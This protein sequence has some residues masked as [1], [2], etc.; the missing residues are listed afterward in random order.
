MTE[1][2]EHEIKECIAHINAMIAYCNKNDIE[3]TLHL[4]TTS[5]TIEINLSPVNKVEIQSIVYSTE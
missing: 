4:L 1:N 2:R 3:V 5:D